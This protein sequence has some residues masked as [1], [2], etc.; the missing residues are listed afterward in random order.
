MNVV[1]ELAAVAAGIALVV[2]GAETFAEHL[3]GAAERLNVSAFALAV[4]L[5]GAEPEELATTVTASLRDVPAVA[6]GDVIGAN[7]AICLVALGVGAVLTPLPFGP[8]VRRYGVL[9]LPLGAVATIVGWDGRIGRD[10]GLVL[11]GLYVAYVASIWLI[12]RRP[13]VLGETAELEASDRNPG[14][15]GRVGRELAFVVVGVAAMAGGALLLVES[16]RGLSDVEATQTRLGLVLVG[17]ATAFELVVLAWSAARRGITE[18]V[19]AGVV[20][21][22]AYNVTVSLGAGAIARPLRITDAGQLHGPWLAML[23]ALA[24]VLV[25]AWPHRRLERPAGWLLLALY[26]VLVVGVLVR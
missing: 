22:F 6:F 23:G 16:V 20:G 5:A 14:S 13:P 10:E 11:V 26:P 4:L 8:S 12:E 21:S 25:V 1:V 17:F 19:V 7:I 3:V 15:S 9:A 18:A 24:L 2:W